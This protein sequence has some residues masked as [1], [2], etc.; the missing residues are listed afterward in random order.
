MKNTFG[1]IGLGLAGAVAAVGLMSASVQTATAEIVLTSS[2]PVETLGTAP[3]TYDFTY[4]LDFGNPN[5]TLMSSGTYAATVSLTLAGTDSS[6]SS[7]PT[8]TVV[9]T[10]ITAAGGAFGAA[11]GISSTNTSTNG[12]TYQWNYTGGSYTSLSQ[13]EAIG[14]ITV[15]SNTPNAIDPIG[16]NYSSIAA[17]NVATN[18]LNGQSDENLANV[19]VPNIT[20]TPL[21][22]LPLPAA[23]WPGL[24]T[25]GGM[26]VVGGLRLR[27]R[28]V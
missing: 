13:N 7:T 5:V 12:L 14:Y 25:L 6:L 24:L 9:D 10:G 1:T 28:T 26:A 15:V 16:N 17:K 19:D 20:G 21:A 18:N 23:F 8:L 11:G 3:G 2:S 27:R 22:S 4:Y